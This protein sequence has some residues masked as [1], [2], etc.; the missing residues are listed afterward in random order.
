MPLFDEWGLRPFGHEGPRENP[1]SVVPLLAASA[2]LN[3][4]V[5]AGGKH[6]WRP[7]ARVL[8]RRSRWRLLRSHPRE[9][10]TLA[11]GRQLRG[12]CNPRLLRS[13]PP[14]SL[15]V[16]MRWSPRA[17]LGPVLPRLLPRAPHRPRPPLVA[18]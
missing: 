4:R 12:R 8:K 18:A 9:P 17:P 2:K 14:R 10:T 6:R 7:E 5:D 1:V 11:L 13:K 3:P 15:Q 16:D